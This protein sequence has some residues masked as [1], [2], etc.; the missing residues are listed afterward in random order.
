MCSKVTQ[1]T[2]ERPQRVRART[3][4]RG[5]WVGA[6]SE[7]WILRRGS[8][9]HVQPR[10]SESDAYTSSH[11]SGHTTFANASTQHSQVHVPTSAIARPN[12][13][14]G[15]RQH[16]QS[17]ACANIYECLRALTPTTKS[18]TSTLVLYSSMR[19][20]EGKRNSY[21]RMPQYSY[22]II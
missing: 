2:T 20:R 9:I 17:R 3:A 14:K 21:P 15:T 1:S 18:S 4:T 13:R 7:T 22:A 10:L 11:V 16:Q 8:R 12:T 5:C 19:E 6:G